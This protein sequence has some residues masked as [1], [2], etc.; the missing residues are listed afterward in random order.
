MFLGYAKNYT[1]VKQCYTHCIMSTKIICNLF[2]YF[3]D[4]VNI[5]LKNTVDTYITICC[6]FYIIK[7]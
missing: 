6:S 3:E 5:I 4:N 2:L 7:N 1:E